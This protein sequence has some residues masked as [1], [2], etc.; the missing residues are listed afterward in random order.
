MA[1]LRWG[2]LL[3]PAG[4]QSSLFLSKHLEAAF[5]TQL[6][7]NSTQCIPLPWPSSL[8][9]KHIVPQLA[10]GRLGQ[11]SGRSGPVVQAESPLE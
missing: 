2:P 9:V 8:L 3:A 11:L 10:S 1:E 6:N 7:E 4:A 5:K